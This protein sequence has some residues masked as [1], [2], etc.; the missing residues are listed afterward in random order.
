[1]RCNVSWAT[2]LIHENLYARLERER[3][4][5]RQRSTLTG[6]MPCIIAGMAS[7]LGTMTTYYL[8][9]GWLTLTAAC[10]SCHV[11][12]VLTFCS[13][14]DAEGGS[15]IGELPF[16]MFNMLLAVRYVRADR[17]T[18]FRYGRSP[19]VRIV[20][21]INQRWNEAGRVKDQQPNFQLAKD[22]HPPLSNF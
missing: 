11:S 22:R 17:M 3:P 2:L 10:T 13:D 20:L 19:A 12:P 6:L 18:L 15:D 9:I 8:R 16:G 5:S 1:M 7:S 21:W 14:W 4:S